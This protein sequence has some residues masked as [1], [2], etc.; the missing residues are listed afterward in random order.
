MARVYAVASAKG[1]VGKTTTAASLA[2]ALSASGADVAAVDADLGMPNLAGAL[3]VEVDG[4]TVHDLL[5]GH[6]DAST[7]LRDGA[8]GVAVLPGSSDLDAYREADPSGLSVALEPLDDYDYVVLD[9]GAGLSH[10][11][12]VPLGLADE[13]LLVSTPDRDA[14]A[15]TAR[16]REVADRIGATVTGAALT[17]VRNDP[18]REV[19]AEAAADRLGVEVLAIVPE[20]D[21]V[22]RA[23]ALGRPVTSFAPHG[24]AA[25][26]YRELART[27][28]GAD[29]PEPERPD[30]VA[31]AGEPTDD[32]AAGE[33]ADDAADVLDEVPGVG[34]NDD[35]ETLTE[36]DLDA[37]TPTGD[38]PEDEAGY[39]TGLGPGEGDDATD[40]PGLGELGTVGSVDPAGRTPTDAEEPSEAPPAPDL[41]D[42]SVE[43]DADIDSG[44]ID[45]PDPA[46]PTDDGPDAG[47]G[48]ASGPGPGLE[49]EHG[50]EPDSEPG[51]EASD[52]PATDAGPSDAATGDE[53]EAVE[54][55]VLADPDATAVGEG[56]GDGTGDDEDRGD[57][58]AADDGDEDDGEDG[59][60]KGFFSRLF[61]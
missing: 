24:P 7:A 19:D 46:P 60:K 56:R 22:G 39:A 41:D 6:G 14:L 36:A 44:P 23:A 55:T 58:G 16:T 52:E 13:T 12:L 49:P 4:V 53:A 29:V 59:R 42:V 21:D 1:G 5:A 37:L 20:D 11:T 38:Q 34:L 43:S 45:D 9:T 18:D 48:A 32:A 10:D 50:H 26:A 15:D 17:R 33:S 8:A 31:S 40:G 2:A 57:D 30:G 35:V 28:T 54:E 51:T 25:A 47:G 3:G 27:L 61:G